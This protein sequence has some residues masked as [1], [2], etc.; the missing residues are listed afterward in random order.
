[1]IIKWFIGHCPHVCMLCK[2]RKDHCC[3]QEMKDC[4]WSD[5]KRMWKRRKDYM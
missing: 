5:V 2:Y 4:T 1:M 3:I